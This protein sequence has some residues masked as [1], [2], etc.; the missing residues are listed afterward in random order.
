MLSDQTKHFLQQMKG[1]PLLHISDT[2]ADGYDR[3]AQLLR[4]IRPALLI[5][6]GD[7]ADEYKLRRIPELK[8]AYRA[9]VG[10]LLALLKENAREVW[11][12]CGNNDDGP[13]LAQD[14]AI[15]LL[16]MDGSAQMFYGLRLFLQ[17]RPVG[18]LAQ[19]DYDFALYGHGFTGD[20]HDPAQNRFGE[21][22]YI[23]GLRHA[24]LIDPFTKQFRHIPYQGEDLP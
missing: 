20:V 10:G 4:Q 7:M 22:C 11:V 21:L 3:L 8:P 14:K 2:R 19:G 12:V 5:H 16:P 17:H 13:W 6:T 15:T 23:N 24:T 18:W 1:P 9:A